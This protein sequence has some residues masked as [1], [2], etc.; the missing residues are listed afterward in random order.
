MS[1][2]EPLVIG[3]IVAG[4][5]ASAVGSEMQGREQSRAAQMEADQL[6]IQQAQ[7]SIASA[8]D[9]AKRRNDLTASMETIQAIRAGRGVGAGSPTGLAILDTMVDETSRNIAS[10]KLNFSTRSDLAGRAATMADRKAYTSLLA[11]DL[12][13]VS[14][15][16]NTVTKAYGPGSGRYPVSAKG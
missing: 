14:A 8:Q 11:G 4:G 3:A 12:G 10:E 1:G 2:L 7:Y 6:R 13:A 5:A 9:E 15:V 16:S